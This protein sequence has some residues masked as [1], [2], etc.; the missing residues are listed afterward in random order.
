MVVTGVADSRVHFVVLFLRRHDVSGLCYL[1]ESM[2]RVLF[3]SDTKR[4]RASV[5]SSFFQRSHEVN[6]REAGSTDIKVRASRALIPGAK[7]SRITQVASGVVH[8][9]SV[10]V[11]SRSGSSPR[12][13]LAHAMDK[14]L[15][16]GSN[17]NKLVGAVTM[18]RAVLGRAGRAEVV[19]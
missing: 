1:D 11:R 12:S 9:L 18:L 4:T 19:V 14:D 5:S 7:H 13:G 10:S 8:G 16:W 17:A 2:M 3:S 15:A 6:S